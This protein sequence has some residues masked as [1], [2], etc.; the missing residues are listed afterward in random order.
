MRY[1]E[2]IREENFMT[3]EEEVNS[4]TYPLAKEFD[5][6]YP[7]YCAV[8][9][10]LQTA[11]EGRERS[12]Q[13]LESW[14]RWTRHLRYERWVFGDFTAFVS[15]FWEQERVLRVY[16]IEDSSRSCLWDLPICHLVFYHI[17]GRITVEPPNPGSQGSNR[18][19]PILRLWRSLDTLTPSHWLDLVEFFDWRRW[20]L[21]NDDM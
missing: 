13:D 1:F 19:H 7:W 12:R 8:S 4:K 6:D 18:N 15:D 5:D 14:F 17:E 16:E 11:Q 2:F 9:R 21:H 20:T 10:K 3:D